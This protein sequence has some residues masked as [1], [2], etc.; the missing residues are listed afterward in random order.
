MRCAICG[1][2]LMS[3]LFSYV[4]GAKICS[5]CTLKF[6]GGRPDT[7]NAIAEARTALGLSEGEYLQ[8]DNGAEAAAILGRR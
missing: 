1:T 2:N 3:D 4:T 7:A 6:V 8:Q 5:I